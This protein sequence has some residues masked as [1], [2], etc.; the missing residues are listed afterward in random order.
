MAPMHRSGPL[1][2]LALLLA[3]AGCASGPGGEEPPRSGW[4]GIRDESPPPPAPLKG[5]LS[6]PTPSVRPYPEREFTAEE[7]EWFDRAWGAFKEGAAGW[8][9][10]RDRWRSMGPEAEG[11]LAWNLYRAM[12]AS[13]AGGAL[14]L[15][16]DARRDLVLMGEG[17]VPALVAGLSVRAVR[18]EDG[19]EVR[20]GQEVLHDAAETLSL[21]G[22]PAVPGLLDIAGSGEKGLVQEAVHALGNIGDPR[23]EGLLLRLAGDRDWALRGAA[24]LAL[25]RYRTDRAREALLA[26]LE[27][28]ESFVVQRASQAMVTEKRTDCLP[29]LV[30]ALD[31]GSRAGRIFTVRAAGWALQRITGESLGTDVAA[32]RS[33]LD[34]NR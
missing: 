12:V 31:R 32:W 1:P 4:G 34:G 8:P 15:V 16:E 22:E 2:A 33:W 7:R 20:V 24:V 18:R 29:G 30:E 27:D 14:H 21:I 19:S 28:P 17:A 5:S 3:L 25:R 26:A 9:E 6:V 11:L 13:R 23:A 10:A